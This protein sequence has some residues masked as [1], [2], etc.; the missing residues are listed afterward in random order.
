MRVNLLEYMG[1]RLSMNSYELLEK[2]YTDVETLY[3]SK[4]YEKECCKITYSLK[5][6]YKVVLK[7][8]DYVAF[9]K[10]TFEIIKQVFGG[11]QIKIA[12]NTIQ[13]TNEDVQIIEYTRK[14]TSEQ[15]V[16]YLNSVSEYLSSLKSDFNELN[17]VKEH[18][19]RELL[20]IEV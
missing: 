18:F 12:D 11:Y 13:V 2:I 10:V 4:V 20:E 17:A 9:D 14:I 8:P 3:K 16:K 15:F 19:E 6:G 5:K 1:E 7:F